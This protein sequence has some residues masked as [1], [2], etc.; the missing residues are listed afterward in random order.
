MD[1]RHEVRK[2]D[3][4]ARR[5]ALWLIVAAAAFGALVLAGVFGTGREPPEWLVQR[6]SQPDSAQGTL[7][8]VAVIAM[9]PV[10]ALSCYLF[11]LG[12][13]AV[14]TRHFPPPGLPALR[15]PPT[16]EGQPA[17]R[18]GRMLQAFA[19]V[20]IGVAAMVPVLMWQLARLLT[21]AG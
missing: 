19:V 20:L 10:F 1:Q 12:S 6:L 11:V 13:R 14:R 17:V 18:R 16:I 7:L 8:A 15:N 21:L 9:L 2:A 5:N 4:R 3:S